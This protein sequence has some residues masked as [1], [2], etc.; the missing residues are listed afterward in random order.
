MRRRLDGPAGPSSPGA[1]TARV[2]GVLRQRL[3]PAAALLWRDDLA[4][5]CRLARR[6]RAGRQLLGRGIPPRRAGALAAPC[7]TQWPDARNRQRP[8]SWPTLDQ[9]PHLRGECIFWLAAAGRRCS[10]GARSGA[11]CQ[12][13]CERAP[14]FRAAAPRGGGFGLEARERGL[15]SDLLAAAQEEIIPEAFQR[16]PPEASSRPPFSSTSDW[17]SSSESWTAAPCGK[18]SIFLTARNGSTGWALMGHRRSPSD[19]RL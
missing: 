2:G 8:V 4:S 13:R 3:R 12:A 1:R 5:V 7:P 17:R 15:L 14:T 10:S 11:D 19:R 9:P 16:A 18:A 6:V